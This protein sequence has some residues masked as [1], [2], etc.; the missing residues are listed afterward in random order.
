[1]IGDSGQ[2]VSVQAG[3][4]LRA[5]GGGVGRHGL[6]EVLRQRDADERRALGAHLDRVGE[7]NHALALLETAQ[8]LHAQL[9]QLLEVWKA[10]EG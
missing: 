9:A 2:L 5:V 8:W 1:V 6:T 3:G 4:W 7:D 10:I